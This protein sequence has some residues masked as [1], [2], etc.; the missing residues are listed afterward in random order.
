LGGG[1]KKRPLT[2]EKGESFSLIETRPKGP[3]KHNDNRG[4]KKGEKKKNEWGKEKG[5]FEANAARKKGF[6]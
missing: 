5:F 2:W 1:G 6:L 4:R 3:A